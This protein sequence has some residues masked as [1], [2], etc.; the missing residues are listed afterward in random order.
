MSNEEKYVVVPIEYDGE[1]GQ[2]DFE[3][4]SHSTIEATREDM[5]ENIDPDDYER[6]AICKVIE[7]FKAGKWTLEEKYCPVTKK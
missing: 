7:V 4:Y 3:S 1:L 2:I 6:V 5:E